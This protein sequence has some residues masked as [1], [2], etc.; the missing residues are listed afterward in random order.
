MSFLKS[1]YIKRT[2]AQVDLYKKI[3]SAKRKRFKVVACMILINYNQGKKRCKL[4]HLIVDYVGTGEASAVH[5]C[6]AV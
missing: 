5:T 2:L 1:I 4:P 6:S 3:P